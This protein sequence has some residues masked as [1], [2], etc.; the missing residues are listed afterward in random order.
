MHFWLAFF[1][2]ICNRTRAHRLVQVLLEYLLIVTGAKAGIDP[3]S[4]YDSLA[5]VWRWEMGGRQGTV[6]GTRTLSR[7]PCLTAWAARSARCSRRA[8]GQLL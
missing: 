5:Q 7:R 3:V 2:A 8:R 6:G 4:P 1:S